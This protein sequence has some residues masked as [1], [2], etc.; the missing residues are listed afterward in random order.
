MVKKVSKRGPFL[1][2]SAY[3]KCKSTMNI[4]EDGK[5]APRKSSARGA[6]AAG[7]RRETSPAAA[8]APAAAAAPAA[9][10]EEKCPECGRAMVK[11][12][13]KRGPFLGCSAYPKCKGTMP[14]A[15]AAEA[16]APAPRPAAQAT[17]VPCPNCGKMMVIREGKWGKFFACP[18]Y[19]KCKT[20]MK[21]GPDGSPVE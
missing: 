1:A 8:P 4:S 18:G 21:M 16:A 9:T 10:V 19:P 20:T 11:R 15:E 7:P 12:F 14:L 17:D 2:C 3:P 6:A 5:P 13:S